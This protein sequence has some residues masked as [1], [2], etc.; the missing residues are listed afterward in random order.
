MKS[1]E[2]WK[3]KHLYYFNPGTWY[4]YINE[5]RGNVYFVVYEMAISTEITVKYL[6]LNVAKGFITEKTYVINKSEYPWKD[7]HMR[8]F[9]NTTET[10][11]LLAL[12]VFKKENK[13]FPNSEAG[14][15]CKNWYETNLSS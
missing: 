9:D 15:F 3:G 14:N 4:S 11:I 13:N 5:K 10:E 1:L 12:K 8:A 2:V 6:Y 7:F